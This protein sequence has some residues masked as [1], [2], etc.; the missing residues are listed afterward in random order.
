MR[1]SNMAKTHFEFLSTLSKA[2]KNDFFQ[3]LFSPMYTARSALPNPMRLL[4][5][6]S[7]VTAESSLPGREELVQLETPGSADQKYNLSF[8]V[9]ANLPPSDPVQVWTMLSN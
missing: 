2:F 4:I 7:G 8:Q 3:L 1:A 5:S 9:V 6:G